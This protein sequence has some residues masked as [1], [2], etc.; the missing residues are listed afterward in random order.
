M[1]CL[2]ISR[3]RCNP[4]ASG[5]PVADLSS[6]AV[7]YR[8]SSSL[9]LHDAAAVIPAASGASHLYRDFGSVNSLDNVDCFSTILRNYRLGNGELDRATG[10]RARATVDDSSTAALDTSSRRTPAA[11]ATGDPGP[12]FNGFLLQPGAPSAKSK[13]QK[14]SHKDRKARSES[15]SAGASIFR[16]L[17]G[18]RSDPYS[19]ADAA[20]EGASAESSPRWLEERIRKKAFSHY[21]CQSIGVS[22]TDVVKRR[23]GSSG[24]SSGGGDAPF[25]AVKPAAASSTSTSSTGTSTTSVRVAG[26][27][28]DVVRAPSHAD[29]QASDLYMYSLIYFQCL[30]QYRNFPYV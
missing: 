12:V 1:F 30:L 25:L 4:G 15:G 21:D 11:A 14:S 3:A 13:S 2:L 17:R 5:R 20:S 24:S 6:S 18:V 26:S 8:S 10:G 29:D 23:S 16:K 19:G 9:E 7:L 27:S 28:V 22:V